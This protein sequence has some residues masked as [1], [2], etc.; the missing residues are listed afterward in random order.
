MYTA[1]G[2]GAFHPDDLP[3][4]IAR[5]A[6]MYADRAPFL[7]EG[8]V[9]VAGETRFIRVR[10]DASDVNA[11]V[12]PSHG[13]IE[14]ITDQR[15]AEEALR[16]SE[17]RHRL[18]AENALDVIWTMAPDGRITY[19]SPSVEKLRG[20]TVAEAMAQPLEEILTPE[21][22]A[23]SVGY[24][25]Y[26]LGEIAEGRRPNDF[27]GEEEYLC[28]DGS[29]VWCEVMA[30]PIL[31][32]DG[33]LVELL[34]VSRDIGE[35]KRHEA[36]L[37][38]A[39][40]ELAE[41][42]RIAHTGSWTWDAATKTGMW[43]DELFRI[44]G[45]EPGSGQLT[46][47]ERRSFVDR[48][49]SIEAIAAIDA[50]ID[51]GR[52]DEAEYDIVRADGARRHVVA[53]GIPRIAPD[54]TVTGY[55]VE[56]LGRDRAAAGDGPTGPG[57][58]GGDR[59]PTGRG[60][61]AR[62][63]QPPHGDQRAPRAGG[64]RRCLRTRPGDVGDLEQ[65]GL[66]AAG[67]AVALSR[68]LLMSPGVQV[69]QPARRRPERGASGTSGR[70]APSSHRR[71]R[72]GPSSISASGPVPVL[73][74]PMQL[75]QVIVNLVRQRARRDAGRWAAS[76]SSRPATRRRSGPG[77]P[78]RRRALPKRGGGV[79]PRDSHTG[80]GIAPEYDRHT[81][82]EPFFTTKPRRRG[83]RARPL[84]SRAGRGPSRAAS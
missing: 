78:G 83:R 40:A 42:Q 8:R 34:G 33:S 65:I 68:Q 48:T 35:R 54:G 28:K 19:V 12:M 52:P 76:R 36:E 84:L 17:E 46:T 61:R 1:I 30:Y 2:F 31:A 72:R 69:L 67:R 43:S 81:I 21:S 51:A 66:G 44:Y 62:L 77:R 75:Q 20:Y 49:T 59:R 39:N 58:A 50:A 56:P 9:I 14:D 60:C 13:Y 7:W 82:F 37:I 16:A 79:L 26:M 71:R 11:D 22:A 57:A 55:Q 29:T 4:L 38:A 32:D 6:Q 27:R 53:R 15:A 18:I 47:A 41:A 25:M 45:L 3:S 24:F 23:V 10:A 63:Q 64:G 5:A 70:D 74:D 80:T 73:A